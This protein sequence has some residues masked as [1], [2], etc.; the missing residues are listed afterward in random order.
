MEQENEP[1]EKIEFYANFTNGKIVKLKTN[2]GEIDLSKYLR[3]SDF[4]IHTN[5]I[6]DRLTDKIINNLN[7]FINN[8]F[9]YTHLKHVKTIFLNSIDDLQNIIVNV[10]EKKYEYA[11]DNLVQGILD[12][13]VR[14]FI[15]KYALNDN[16][17]I[18]YYAN[19]Y[20]VNDVF[21]NV[22]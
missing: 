21:N 9:E 18:K 20:G 12:D 11:K 14:P 22:V 1:K 10:D 16:G 17:I 7:Y 2:K 6:T 3:K 8:D 5:N 19:K 13:S 15:R 4:N